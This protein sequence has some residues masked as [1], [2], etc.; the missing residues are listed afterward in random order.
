MCKGGQ[1]EC[2]IQILNQSNCSIE[3]CDVIT[4]QLP[5]KPCVMRSAR[6]IVYITHHVTFGTSDVSFE[7]H[8]LHP[9]Y[10]F[11]GKRD[12]VKSVQG[13]L[14]I[15]TSE[16][17]YTGCLRKIKTSEKNY[18]W[19]LRKIIKKDIKRGEYQRSTGCPRY[20]I[21]MTYRVSTTSGLLVAYFRVPASLA[22]LTYRVSHT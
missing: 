5:R 2:I 20:L 12:E 13:V 22:P 9:T 10:R 3:M 15:K 17:N 6:R 8:G 14:K 7:L 21:M 19:C 11:P 18:T 4:D 1:S 16:K